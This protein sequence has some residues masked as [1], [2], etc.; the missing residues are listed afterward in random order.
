MAPEDMAY[1]VGKLE[2]A[3]CRDILLGN[4]DLFRYG[5]LVNDFRG[6]A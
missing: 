1:V 6:L 5:R 3:G 4:G 2:S